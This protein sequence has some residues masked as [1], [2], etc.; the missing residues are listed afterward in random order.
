[1]IDFLSNWAEQLVVAVIIAT[2]IEMIL[3]NNNNKKYIKI[4]IFH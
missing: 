1:M 2:I 3:P 4:V